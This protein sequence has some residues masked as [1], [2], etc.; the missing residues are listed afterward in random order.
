MNLLYDLG[1]K[2]SK[3]L[4]DNKI[5]KI[6]PDIIKHIPHETVILTNK[7]YNTS[8]DNIKKILAKMHNK[9]LSSL[10][11]N[12][13]NFDYKYIVVDRLLILE[14]ILLI[15]KKKILRLLK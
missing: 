4:D 10:V 9:A 15:L 2:D 7:E 8:F 5:L 1:V 3:R 11:N 6:G 12:N 14:V 13:N